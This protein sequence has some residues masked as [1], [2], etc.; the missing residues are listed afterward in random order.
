[1]APRL[2][3]GQLVRQQTPNIQRSSQPAR[4]PNRPCTCRAASG[5]GCMAKKLFSLK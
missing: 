3:I 5:R 1:M 4:S 2:H